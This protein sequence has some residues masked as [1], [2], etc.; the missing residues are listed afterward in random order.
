[1]KKKDEIL[2]LEDSIEHARLEFMR[3]YI[4]KNGLNHKPYSRED[5]LALYEV[6]VTKAKMKKE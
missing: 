6:L 5:L 4:V 3:K 1:M 2:I